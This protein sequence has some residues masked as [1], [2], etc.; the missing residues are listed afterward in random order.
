MAGDQTSDSAPIRI[1]LVYLERRMIRGHA[2]FA[3]LLKLPLEKLLGTHCRDFTHPE[4]IEA[5]LI[6]FP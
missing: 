6:L 5:D 1:A 4:Y 2:A 3:K